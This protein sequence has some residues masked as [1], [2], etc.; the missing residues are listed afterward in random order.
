[1]KKLLDLMEAGKF[2][3]RNN[4]A[5]YGL[6]SKKMF[7]N[8]IYRLKKKG[9]DIRDVDEPEGK[10]YYIKDILYELIRNNK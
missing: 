8:A 7:D 1:M 9:H 10:A 3:S 2:V 4:Y 6:S 5:E